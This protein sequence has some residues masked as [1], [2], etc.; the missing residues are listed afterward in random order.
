MANRD[1]TF[2]N[3]AVPGVYQLESTDGRFV[4]Y[5]YVDSTGKCVQMSF[6][7]EL[8]RKGWNPTVV[9]RGPLNSKS[10]RIE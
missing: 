3:L 8:G 5:C 4:S 1:K 7:D 6:D 9:I 10:Q 2:T